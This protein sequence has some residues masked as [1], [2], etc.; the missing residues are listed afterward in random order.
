[1]SWHK[2]CTVK[3]SCKMQLLFFFRVENRKSSYEEKE[4]V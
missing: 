4:N 3:S 2:Y 1:M